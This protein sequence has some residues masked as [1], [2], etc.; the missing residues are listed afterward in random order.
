MAWTRDDNASIEKGGLVKLQNGMIGEI[1][2]VRDTGRYAR[3]EILINGTRCYVERK[4]VKLAG[5]LDRLAHA[6]SEDNDGKET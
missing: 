6:V 3:I 5:I 1:I 2:G 4:D